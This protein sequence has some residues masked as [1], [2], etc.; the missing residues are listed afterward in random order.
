MTGRVLILDDDAAVGETIRFVA[1]SAGMEARSFFR[2][3]AFFE[4]IDDWAPTHIVLDLVMP[5]MDGV[6]IM[7]HL[8]ER[9]C[10]AR[11]LIL[12]GVGTR[13]LDAARRTASEKGLDVAG[14]LSKP[15]S[16]KDLNDFFHGGT[17]ARQPAAAAQRHR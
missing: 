5:E 1:E 8:S 4:A 15:I 3:Q 13:V 11:I 2:P 10:N 12:S 6:E 16:P 17:A 7:R 14:V 9:R